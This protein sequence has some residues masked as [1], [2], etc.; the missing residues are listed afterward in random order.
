MPPFRSEDY[1][2]AQASTGSNNEESL[3][4]H[5]MNAAGNDVLRPLVNSAVIEPVNTLRVF[6]KVD[7]LKVTPEVTYSPQWFLQNMSSGLGALVP[8]TIAGK[9]AG[10]TLR[11]VGARF[12]VTGEMAAF[13]QSEKVAFVAG[14]AAYDFAK[15]LHE[16]ETRL[17]N[18]AG[19]AAAFYVF[20]LGNDLTKGWTGGSRIAGKL[21][22]GFAGA[23]AQLLV[24][25][26]ISQGELPTFD[27][28]MQAGVS[29]AS[30]NM[31][32][33]AVQDYTS[34]KMTELQVNSRFGAPVDQYMRYQ[35]PGMS[36]DAH[37]QSLFNANPWARVRRG[38]YADFDAKR[39]MIEV[40]TVQESPGA[41]AK[42]LDSI[43]AARTGQFETQFADA[44][45]ILRQGKVDAAWQRFAETRAAQELQF[46]QTEN[47][48]DNANK[49][50]QRLPNEHMAQELPAWIAP[51]GVS[52]E[53][54][55]RQEFEQFRKTDGAWRPGEKLSPKAEPFD[56]NGEAKAREQRLASEH[57]KVATELVRE[58]QKA[59]FMAV[60][61][62]GSVRDEVMG[63][64]AKDYDIA[65]RAT[66]DQVQHVFE[67]LGYKTILTGKQFGVINVV[68][69][70]TQFEIA[71][72]RTDGNY[73][74][75]RRPDG[76]KFVNSLYED[77][78]R[79]DLTINA[80][81]KDPTTGRVFD[82]FGGRQDIANKIIRT[83]GDPVK[84]FEEDSL[85]MLRIPRFAS[86]YE[87]DVDPATKDAISA[88][89]ERINSVSSERI[90][91]EVKGTLTT[92]AP[93][94]GLDLMMETGLMRRILPEVADLTG[95][96]AMQDPRWH[97]EGLTWTH[98][99][100]VLGGLVGS[101]WETMLAGLLHDVGKPATQQIHPDGGISNHGHAEVGAEM[102]R[103]VMN[104]WNTS[105]AE[106]DMVVKLVA[107]HMKL[108]K[109]QEWRKS[110][111]IDLLGSKYFEDHVALQ[112]ADAMG[113]GRTDGA[114]KSM[115]NWL[116]EQKA[117]FG[118]QATVKPL[119]DGKMLI[120]LGLKPGKQIGEI[121]NHALD[122]QREGHFADVES[123]MRWLRENYPD[124]PL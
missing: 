113:T 106:K 119:I 17:G 67:S 60:F 45:G 13:L 20:G 95:P 114:S 25:R 102:A 26:G 98:T 96:K 79:R 120:D 59:G 122:A 103:G 1:V 76:V 58:L 2:T 105:N 123:A 29:G 31:V 90:R 46:H 51:G 32:L 117:Q 36:L 8:Y 92:K 53:F 39:N 100:M 107:D 109:V 43:A 88:N 118:D 34:R 108:H 9:A 69:G 72:L 61:A 80:M 70:E 33:P 74:D 7:E 21:A 75:G 121:K 94:V 19:G 12:A 40:P 11:S 48:V 81:F 111:L 44:A 50:V 28:F 99:R 89:A 91:E 14:A 78:A 22:T 66:P 110:R 57:E 10:S 18:A 93:L 23:D 101:R 56:P 104:R 63:R 115:R 41:V 42:G 16:G 30:M 73:S 86:R 52:Q 124:L 24:S 54:R 49:L 77:A 6:G 71:S 4:G 38:A 97:P 82:F 64:A 55:W 15:P 62:G 27:Q 65:T 87:F 47:I 85:R 3:F 116:M 68:A 5:V 83:V 37:G 112:H 35:Q 84:R